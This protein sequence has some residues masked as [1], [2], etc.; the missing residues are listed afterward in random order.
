MAHSLRGELLRCA[1]AGLAAIGG[2][3]DDEQVEHG[4]VEQHRGI[5]FVVVGRS[6]IPAHYG[7]CLSI[8][9]VH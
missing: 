5:S 3:S 4:R 2:A 8:V 6:A 9:V 1:G 7:S